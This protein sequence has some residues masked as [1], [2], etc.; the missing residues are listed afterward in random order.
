ASWIGGAEEHLATIASHTFTRAVPEPGG[1]HVH[2]NL[3]LDAGQAP[4]D[5]QPIEI[6]FRA[7]AF[8]RT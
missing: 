1:E 5:G 7:F 4:T 3:W 2:L 8:S 6:I